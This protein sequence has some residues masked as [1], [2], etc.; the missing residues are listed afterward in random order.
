MKV[1]DFVQCPVGI[2]C[3]PKFGYIR[4]EGLATKLEIPVWIIQTGVGRFEPWPKDAPL[5]GLG[6]RIKPKKEGKPNGNHQLSQT[7]GAKNRPAAWPYPGREI[8]EI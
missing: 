6:R 4:K 3:P 7:Q 5:L 1:G 8:P 2:G